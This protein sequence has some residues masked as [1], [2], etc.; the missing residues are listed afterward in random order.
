MKRN[1]KSIFLPVFCV[2]LYILSSCSTGIDL[3]NIDDTSIKLDESLI[4]PV[5]EANLSVKDILS[6]I[7]LP[8]GVFTSD[9]EIFFQ[10]IYRDSLGFDPKI[11]LVDSVKPYTRDIVV[12]D[13]ISIPF[14]PAGKPT[15]II[16]HD[17]LNLGLN[18]GSDQRV[19]RILVDSAVL[20]INFNVSDN[21]KTTYLIPA[22]DFKIEFRFKPEILKVEDG[23]KLEKVPTAYTSPIVDPID[24]K[25][26]TDSIKFHKFEMYV[27]GKNKIPYDIVI[28]AFPNKDLPVDGSKL[29][30]RLGFKRVNLNVA[31]G[32]F[33]LKN[34]FE[35]FVAIPFKI[36]DYLP[37]G[38]LRFANPIVKVHA[39]TNVGA[40]ISVKLDSLKLYRDADPTNKIWSW[41]GDPLNRTK[42][43]REIILGPTIFGDTKT[44][45]LAQYDYK[46]GATDGLFDSK[47]YPDMVNYKFSINSDHSTTRE[48]FAAPDSKMKVDMS[49]NV[50]LY[51]KAGSFYAIADTLRNIN[52]GTI[53]NNVDSA[54][55]VLRVNN[56]IPFKGMLRMTFW[57]SVLPNDTV[58]AIGGSVTHVS[59]ESTLGNITSIYDI[60]SSK[61]Y[62]GAYTDSLGMAVDSLDMNKK[63]VPQTQ[64]I[65][66]MLNKL[67]IEQLKQTSFIVLG[68][69][70]DTKSMVN[71]VEIP[72]PAHL[73]TN[74]GL[75][76]KIG[77]FTKLSFSTNIGSSH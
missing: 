18:D 3:S 66:I 17:S 29:S 23:S 45:D 21:I 2:F 71:G 46:N 24:P 40:D 9:N 15:S 49:I 28:T 53:L 52:V 34:N 10:W 57:K 63:V 44:Q 7:A 58:P 47:P 41:F 32:K 69:L 59:S 13:S 50:P 22:A 77:V 37:Y 27:N 67:Q 1:Y 61:V 14:L 11:N 51:V 54:I 76:V 39:V 8:P 62:L 5:A 4:L 73:T 12:S 16:I 43:K 48:D 60:K 64:T 33:D 65:K 6:N 38:L 26:Y 74:N 35:K 55:L 75:G 36:E 30:M 68:V 31:Y 19:D 42:D 72:T 20:G 70:L 56:K 25:L